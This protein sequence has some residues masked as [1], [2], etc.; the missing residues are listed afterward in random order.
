MRTLH[1]L[2]PP[3][4]SS[5]HPS[6]WDTII[7]LFSSVSPVL[8]KFPRSGQLEIINEPDNG[9]LRNFWKVLRD[10]SMFAT[11][12]RL[13]E[14][15]P[16]DH[17]IVEEAKSILDANGVNG[18]SEEVAAWAFFVCAKQSVR[19]Q[20]TA[21]AAWLTGVDGLE[22][23][24]DRVRGICLT[25]EPASKLLA[26]YS[27]PRLFVIAT[28]PNGHGSEKFL[29]P[30]R[31]TGRQ[32]AILAASLARKPISITRYQ[33]EDL[34]GDEEYEEF[35]EILERPFQGRFLLTAPSEV[36][37][38]R[39]EQQLGWI[40]VADGLGRTTWANFKAKR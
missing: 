19:C 28:P 16:V 11:F 37:Y 6:G 33:F 34:H 36:I 14:A 32:H 7:E 26:R 31:Y 39:F 9:F 25:K 29:G 17:D 23:V 38:L 35:M 1:E 4:A 18:V 5:A 8:L 22:K 27:S 10:E 30:S 3:F 13:A 2:I 24:H 20:K 12:K 15:T 40:R 21:R